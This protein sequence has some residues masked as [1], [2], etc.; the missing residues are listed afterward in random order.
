MILNVVGAL[1]HPTELMVM[2]MIII[3]TMGLV[4]PSLPRTSRSSWEYR[5][6]ILHQ[7]PQKKKLKKIKKFILVV[8]LRQLYLNK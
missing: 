1:F 2:I 3:T 4:G 8:A 5:G 6:C 7:L